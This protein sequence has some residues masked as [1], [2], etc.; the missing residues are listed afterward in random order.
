VSKI[1][2]I[3]YRN[4]KKIKFQI[5]KNKLV[6]WQNEVLQKYILGRKKSILV[7]N[8]KKPPRLRWFLKTYFRM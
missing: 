4:S 8:K 3:F 6:Y 1:K 2:Y 5:P 7:I